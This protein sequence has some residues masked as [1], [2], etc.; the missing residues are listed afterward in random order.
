LGRREVRILN[1]LGL[2]VANN[3][4]R[5]KADVVLILILLVMENC[6]L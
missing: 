5:L 2:F 4:E 6:L 3:K 1:N